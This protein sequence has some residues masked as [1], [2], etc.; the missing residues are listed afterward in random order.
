MTRTP[1]AGVAPCAPG[2]CA[3]TASSRRA[4]RWGGFT[5][6]ELLVVIA[7]IA[8]L[9]AILMP[10]LQQAK[11]LAQR[12][13]CSIQLRSIGIAV[14]MYAD[15]NNEWLPFAIGNPG[16]GLMMHDDNVWWGVFPQGGPHRLGLLYCQPPMKAGGVWY[17]FTDFDRAGYVDQLEVFRCT[18]QDDPVHAE[19]FCDEERE[20]Q[21]DPKGWRKGKPVTKR[22][23]CKA[24]CYLLLLTNS[25]I[26]F[27]TSRI[28]S[29]LS[30]GYKGSERT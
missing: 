25:L 3:N 17:R 20:D 15:E 27:T 2:G 21:P 24:G 30:S 23:Y 9:V 12:A 16:V 18:R 6:I 29:S 4:R 7:I 22:T 13:K 10:S 8:L 11:E 28:C 26:P 1:S 19:Y 5:L 14:N